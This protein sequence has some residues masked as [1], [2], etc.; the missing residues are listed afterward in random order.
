MQKVMETNISL[1]LPEQTALYE[2]MREWVSL[3][4]MLVL[5][6]WMEF[7]S[8]GELVP[9]HMLSMSNRINRCRT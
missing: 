8:P 4:V 5:M 9:V 3:V 7:S 2:A 6:E 1:A